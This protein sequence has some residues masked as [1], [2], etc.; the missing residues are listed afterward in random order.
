MHQQMKI[1]VHFTE[2][3][4]AGK[5]PLKQYY[6][7]EIAR[8]NFQYVTISTLWLSA[9]DYPVLLG[10]FSNSCLIMLIH[11]QVQLPDAKGIG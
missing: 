11:C 5:G 6:E 3:M 4:Y 8:K 1:N 2:S 7:K 10:M 9:E